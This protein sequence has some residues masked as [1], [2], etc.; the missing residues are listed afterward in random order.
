MNLRGCCYSSPRGLTLIDVTAGFPWVVRSISLP[1][2]RCTPSPRLRG[3]GWGEGDS[4]STQRVQ[5]PPHPLAWLHSRC[6]VSAFLALRTAAEGRL[7]SPR[8]RGEV[9]L[10]ARAVAVSGFTFAER[11]HKTS[12]ARQRQ[13]PH[14]GPARRRHRAGGHGPRAR[15]PRQ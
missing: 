12:H 14:R 5:S 4:Q 15:R 7:C 13:L 6:F 10:A 8:K 2:A 11:S 1:L 3:E 9:E